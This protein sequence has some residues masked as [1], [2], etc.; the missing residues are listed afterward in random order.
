MLFFRLLVH[1]EEYIIGWEKYI[2]DICNSLM[3]FRFYI[4]KET[5]NDRNFASSCEIKVDIG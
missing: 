2:N 1:G 3:C 4:I 5:F